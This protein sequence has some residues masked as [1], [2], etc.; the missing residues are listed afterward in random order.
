IYALLLS[1]CVLAALGGVIAFGTVVQAGTRPGTTT[2][3]HESQ[4]LDPRG[5][6]QY[7]TTSFGGLTIEG[8]QEIAGHDM[9]SQNAMMQGI[10]GYVGPGQVQVQASV[11]LTNTTGHSVACA[12]TQFQLSYAGA[13][14]LQAPSSASLPTEALQPRTTV[15]GTVSYIVPSDAKSLVLRYH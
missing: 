3:G 14:Q 4:D 13:T 10:P 15:A 1:T 2:G 8:V 7:V 11:M 12:P 9:G 6:A 5:I